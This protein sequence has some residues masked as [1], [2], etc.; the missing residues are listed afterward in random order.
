M[1]AFNRGVAR[2]DGTMA[3]CFWPRHALRL[4]ADGKVTD[5]VICFECLQFRSY[6]GDQQSELAIDKSPLPVFNEEL[7]R[8]GIPWCPL[9]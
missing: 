1:V 7:K 9:L 2:S 3:K 6:L 8:A 5:Y 4:E